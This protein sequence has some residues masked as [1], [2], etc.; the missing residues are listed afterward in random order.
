M[1]DP[2]TMKED[3]TGVEADAAARAAVLTWLRGPPS[4]D[5]RAPTFYEVSANSLIGWLREAGFKIVP[6]PAGELN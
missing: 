5:P 4:A 2:A 6:L 3:R 1:G